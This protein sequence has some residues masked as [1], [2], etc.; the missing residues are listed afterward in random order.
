MDCGRARQVPAQVIDLL[1][2]SLTQPFLIENHEVMSILNVRG[3]IPTVYIGQLEHAPVVV[4]S[5]ALLNI[6]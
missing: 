5:L 4:L 1:E 3:L 6:R 2:L